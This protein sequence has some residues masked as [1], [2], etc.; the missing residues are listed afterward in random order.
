[1][2]VVCFFLR[3]RRDGE[4]IWLL[5]LVFP[6]SLMATA[7]VWLLD[8]CSSS[9]MAAVR[10]RDGLVVGYGVFVD[11][12]SAALIVGF[13][14]LLLRRDVGFGYSMFVFFDCG[15]GKTS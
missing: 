1:L 8:V 9:V 2:V 11:G 6:P 4:I 13:F 14:F 3:L 12:G 10:W 5:D 7:T 15:C